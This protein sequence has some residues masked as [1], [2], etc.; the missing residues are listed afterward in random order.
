ME[1]GGRKGIGR[2]MWDSGMIGLLQPEV[3][4]AIDAKPQVEEGSIG[5]MTL[6][7][8]S[9]RNGV[10]KAKSVEL[11]EFAKHGLYVESTHVGMLGHDGKYA[12]WSSTGRHQQR[13]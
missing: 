10:R 1:E 6:G 13:G 5:M 2:H 8:F 7:F 12:N 11:H 3:S 4:H 9:I